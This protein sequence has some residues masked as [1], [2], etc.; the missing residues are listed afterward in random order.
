MRTAP[1]TAQDRREAR[2]KQLPLRACRGGASNDELE[3]AVAG[4]TALEGVVLR[5]GVVAAKSRAKVSPERS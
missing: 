5:Y 1:S 2:R 4:S 3:G